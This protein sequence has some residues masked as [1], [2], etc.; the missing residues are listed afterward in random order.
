MTNGSYILIIAVIVGLFIFRECEH[1]KE[2]DNMV[3]T[4]ESRESF[5]EKEKESFFAE[6]DIKIND[7]KESKPNYVVSI[8]NIDAIRELYPDLSN[9]SSVIKTEVRTEIKESIEYVYDTT[10]LALDSNDFIHRDSVI[11]NF[12]PKGSKVHKNDLWYDLSIS[13]EDSLIIDSLIMRDKIDAVLAWKKPDKNFKFLR[14]K[15]PV[16]SVQSYNPY[17]KIG[18][19]NNLVV[20]D[21]R[22]KFG[23]IMT[24]KPMMFMYGIIGGAVL[25]NLK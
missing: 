18:Y 15:E 5:F 6:M 9:I 13:L 7:I 24:S 3:S 12:I 1:S 20:K 4:M 22:S 19:V 25:V 21:E 10:Y 14:K 16:V 2:I 8:D 11:A 23:R 17:T